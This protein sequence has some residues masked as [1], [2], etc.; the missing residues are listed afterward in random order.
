M[1]LARKRRSVPPVFLTNA[2]RLTGMRPPTPLEVS[3]SNVLHTA[4]LVIRPLEPTDHDELVRVVAINREHLAPHCPLHRDGE[5]DAALAARLIDMSR[6]G[7]ETGRVWRAGVFGANRRLV[8]L[9]NLNDIV[10]C[11]ESRAE[12]NWW[13]S[14]EHTGRGLATEAVRA[15]I[16]HGFDDFPRGLG[17]QRITALIAPD[18]SA[19][20]RVAAKVG[21]R[22]PRRARVAKS[23]GLNLVLNG[24]DIPHDLYEVFA[25]LTGPRRIASRRPALRAGVAA[26]LS[27]EAA[28]GVH[29]A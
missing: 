27:A 22:R 24:C 5:T 29:D 8:G 13:V 4:R 21:L 15:L 11:I 20:Q 10:R 26:I 14:I 1:L 6:R 25:P 17:L 28:V 3:A 16:D 9:V 23:D 19:S 12:A 2:S 18:N 7:L